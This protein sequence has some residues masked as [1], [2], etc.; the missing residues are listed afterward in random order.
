[1]SK[2]IP[3]MEDEKLSALLRAARP[4]RALPPGFNEAVWRRLERDSRLGFSTG[5][6]GWLDRAA[7][8]FL[9]PRRAAAG[10]A[11]MVL[12]G[13]AVG[14]VQGDRLASDLARQQY[15]AAVSPMTSR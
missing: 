10:A 8:M 9:R 15:L 7:A 13:I 6:P 4:E 1:M 14:V 11:A 2:P 5:L 3:P 12:L